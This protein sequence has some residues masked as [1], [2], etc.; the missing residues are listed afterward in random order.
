MKLYEDR[1]LSS[2]F[3]RISYRALQLDNMVLSGAP[4]C[5]MVVFGAPWF[6]LMLVA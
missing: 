5:W 6:P 2:H 3:V 1:E 4:W